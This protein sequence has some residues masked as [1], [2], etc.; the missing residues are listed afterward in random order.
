MVEGLTA[1]SLPP[2]VAYD[3]NNAGGLLKISLR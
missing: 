1:A 3:G 2:I